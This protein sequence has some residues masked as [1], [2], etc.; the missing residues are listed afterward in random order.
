MKD[1]IGPHLL[2]TKL[3]GAVFGTCPVGRRGDCSK[4]SGRG[5]KE[6]TSV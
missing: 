3:R 5:R 1:F 4:V 2:F 6:V